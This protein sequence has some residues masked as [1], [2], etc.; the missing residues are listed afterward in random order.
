MHAFYCKNLGNVGDIAM[1]ERTESDHLFKTLR[2]RV[3]DHVM[4]LNGNGKSAMAEVLAGKEL[5]ILDVKLYDAPKKR[6]F[7]FVAAPRKQ[8]LDQVLKQATELGVSAICIMHCDYSVALPE[9]S[10]RWEMILLEACKQSNNPFMPEIL[11]VM[12]FQEALSFAK[13]NS[14]A[15]IFGDVEDNQELIDNLGDDI[16]F[17]V[18][19]EGGFSEK[20]L[21]LMRENSFAGLNLGPY[22]LRLETAAICGIAVIRKMLK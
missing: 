1:L 16:A 2:A 15:G 12:K 20:E 5:K 11:P 10:N 3:G 7:L 6:I 4:L 18:G 22:I 19:P 8:K 17:F 13:E 14:L 9:G 21:A